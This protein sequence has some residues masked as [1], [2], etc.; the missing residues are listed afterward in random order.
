MKGGCL[1]RGDVE[2]RWDYRVDGAEGGGISAAWG[3]ASGWRV[4]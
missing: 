2:G 4:G 1:L 3:G